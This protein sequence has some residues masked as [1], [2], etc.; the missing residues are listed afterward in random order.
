VEIFLHF[1]FSD[2][3]QIASIIISFLSLV[4]SSV[5][6]FYSQRLGEYLDVDPSIKMIIFAALPITLQLLFPLFSLILMAAYSKVYVT[7]CTAMIILANA[8]MLNCKCLKPKLYFGIWNLYSGS[9]E[10]K[11]K[12]QK[13]SED[14]FYTAIFT[15]WILP[16]TVWANSF[17][18]MSYFLI[19]NSLTTLLGHAV[20]IIFV[21]I[22]TYCEVL[23]MDPLE[24]KNVPITHC[25]KKEDNFTMR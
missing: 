18:S 21:F 10:N 4:L 8:F 12:K 11:F 1:L 6:L 16:C 2:Y 25:F 23:K 15:S 14:I 17:R 24:T 13:E 7:V 9:E 20:G 5:K 22:L 19:V 3:I